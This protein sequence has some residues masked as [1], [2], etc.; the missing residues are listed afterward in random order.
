LVVSIVAFSTAAAVAAD[1]PIATRKA[2]MDANGAAAGVSASMLKGDLD[3]NPAVAKSAIMTLRAVAH[4]YGS[5]FPE[6]SDKGETKAS[7]KIWS[8]R[9]A[10]EA[11]IDKFKSDADAA[12]TASGKDGPADLAAF[13]TAVLPV[14]NNC[15]SCHQDFRQQ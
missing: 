2:L 12:A 11:A 13:K 10:F 14:F 7:P 1:D 9:A 4:S 3:Y 15:K 6:G 8:D 5:F